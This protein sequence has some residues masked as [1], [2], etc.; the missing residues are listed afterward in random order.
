MRD[1]KLNY[2]QKQRQQLAAHSEQKIFYLN[3][4]DGEDREKH[5]PLPS[6]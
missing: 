3:D 4:P 5:L 1:V 6:E 2:K